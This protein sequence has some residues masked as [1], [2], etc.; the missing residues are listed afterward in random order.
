[1]ARLRGG[2]IHVDL[3]F[4]LF[5][6]LYSFSHLGAEFRSVPLP[7]SRIAPDALSLTYDPFE[8][9][10]PFAGRTKTTCC[11]STDR[12]SESFHRRSQVNPFGL[13]AQKKRNRAFQR[14][15]GEA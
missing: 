6:S 3:R 10:A 8:S 12:A 9:Q 4:A 14:V 15:S 5:D 13:P 11:V 1:M 2:W 7:E